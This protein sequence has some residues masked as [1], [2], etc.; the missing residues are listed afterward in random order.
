MYIIRYGDKNNKVIWKL[1][2][3]LRYFSKKNYFIHKFWGAR[4]PWVI[5]WLRHC[6]SAL[7][8]SSLTISLSKTTLISIRKSQLLKWKEERVLFFFFFGIL[9][10]FL[11]PCLHHRPCA[12]V[13]DDSYIVTCPYILEGVP[14]QLMATWIMQFPTF[15]PDSITQSGNL[16]ILPPMV[17]PSFECHNYA[18]RI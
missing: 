1:S 18:S 16:R 14:Y 4:P 2:N 6:H 11:A 15:P 5:K 13:G 3:Y 7:Y 12:R 8:Y 10:I 17:F 9:H